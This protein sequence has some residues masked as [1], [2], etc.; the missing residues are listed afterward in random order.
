MAFWHARRN[1]GMKKAD[2]AGAEHGAN[3]R[4]SPNYRVGI[5]ACKERQQNKIIDF[6][7]T[8]DLI[9][10]S[11]LSRP[12]AGS[13]ALAD[14]RNSTRRWRCKKPQCWQIK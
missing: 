3:S 14:T 10:R 8:L 2:T 4:C 6:V 7:A 11:V 13:A 5:D 9:A 12:A 1:K